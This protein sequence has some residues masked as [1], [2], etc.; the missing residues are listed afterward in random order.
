MIR[1]L[2]AIIASL[3]IALP[4]GAGEARPNAPQPDCFDSV[5]IID[6]GTPVTLTCINL[7]SNSEVRIEIQWV[8]EG[9]SSSIFVDT[10]VDANGELIPVTFTPANSGGMY[11]IVWRKINFLG[12]TGPHSI[13]DAESFIVNPISLTATSKGQSGCDITADVNPS[14][15]SQLVTFTVD[16]APLNAVGN[17]GGVDYPIVGGQFQWSAP[18]IGGFQVFVNKTRPNGQV[19]LLCWMWQEVM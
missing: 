16:G 19:S 5:Q 12:R 7:K 9:P 18:H 17:I 1:W 3:L 14:A 10:G 8:P 15:V 11:F 2:T 13:L 6:P 4:V